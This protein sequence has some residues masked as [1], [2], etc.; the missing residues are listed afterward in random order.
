MEQQRRFDAELA[1]RLAAQQ[2]CHELELAAQQRRSDAALAA[3]LARIYEEEGLGQPQVHG[4]AAQPAAGGAGAAG[5]AGAGGPPGV[6]THIPSG[7]WQIDQGASD[8]ARV[9]ARWSEWL[10]E[11]QLRYL[12]GWR[13]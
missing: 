2:R 5:A 1:A 4:Q 3:T 11:G 9:L 7:T 6:P 12:V 13:L 10:S 8:V